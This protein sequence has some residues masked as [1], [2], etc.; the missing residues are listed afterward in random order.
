[1]LAAR[2][3]RERPRNAL[4]VAAARRQADAAL[5]TPV[6][7]ELDASVLWDDVAWTVLH[8]SDQSVTLQ[9]VDDGHVAS[10]PIGDVERL[11]RAGAVRA[12][13]GGADSAL[14]ERRSERDVL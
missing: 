12:G 5:A 11:L 10:V 14:A 2:H 9:R 7:L 1:M 13:Q 8:R 3:E 4:G 6:V